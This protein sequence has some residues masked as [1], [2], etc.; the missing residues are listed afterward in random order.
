[1]AVLHTI[2]FSFP[3]KT[4]NTLWLFWNIHGAIIKINMLLQQHGAGRPSGAARSNWCGSSTTALKMADFPM[5][6]KQG[7]MLRMRDVMTWISDTP[8]P[9]FF[10]C[11]KIIKTLENMPTKKLLFSKEKEK[12]WISFL[13]KQPSKT[14]LPWHVLDQLNGITLSE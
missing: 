12:W 11:N 6:Y 14:D 13:L 2:S 8:S 9:H 1:M 5:S 3:G 7:L 4:T 10:H